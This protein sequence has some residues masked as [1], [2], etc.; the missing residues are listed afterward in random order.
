MAAVVEASTS[1]GTVQPSPHVIWTVVV[2]AVLVFVVSALIGLWHYQRKKLQQ[3][4]HSYQHQ[5][6]KRQQQ[7]QLQQQQF[8]D[9]RETDV[10]TF[11]QIPTIQPEPL[12]G[13]SEQNA[14]T[15]STRRI[16]T[17]VR[18][19]KNLKRF[20]E[21]SNVTVATV[22]EENPNGVCDVTADDG[23]NHTAGYGVYRNVPTFNNSNITFDSSGTS[24]S[25]DCAGIH[26]SR[27]RDEGGVTGPYWF[28]S[29]RK[30]DRKTALKIFK[31]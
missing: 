15:T 11:G 25:P 7:D 31:V 1:D 19:S 30:P 18:P 2:C 10:E 12:I 26:V 20:S 8:M 22:V 29:T 14:S 13:S 3:R 23:S 24:S 16:R 5:I 27:L 17:Y 4:R 6:M 28:H 21:E 9:H